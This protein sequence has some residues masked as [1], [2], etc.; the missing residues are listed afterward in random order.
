MIDV[1][2]VAEE[3]S[4][5]MAGQVPQMNF[6]FMISCVIDPAH[7]EKPVCKLKYIPRED[8]DAEEDEEIIEESEED[9][10]DSDDAQKGKKTK[11]KHKSK[12]RHKNDYSDSDS[13]S[14]D[15]DEE[16]GESDP[17][18]ECYAKAYADD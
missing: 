12:S 6:N 17:I 7:P 14:D 4:S 15:E 8:E 5:T 3:I 11:K 1:D 10:E 18:L 13:D 9:S 2:K 16:D